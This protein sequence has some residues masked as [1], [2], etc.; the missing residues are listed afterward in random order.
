MI[1]YL[2]TFEQIQQEA[3]KLINLKIK[4]IPCLDEEVVINL[5]CAFIAVAYQKV[6][7]FAAKYNFSGFSGK[8]YLFK[9][10]RLTGIVGQCTRDGLIGLDLDLVFPPEQ[11][12]LRIEKQI[13][14]L[15]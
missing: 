6:A 5:W 7:F 2:S 10:N 13:M 8:L 1:P 15:F 12:F 4:D 3:Q 11:R 9:S 14:Q